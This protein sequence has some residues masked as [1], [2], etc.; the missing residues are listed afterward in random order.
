MNKSKNAPLTRRQA[1]VIQ[2]LISEKT[3][4]AAA[5]RAG[6]ARSTLYRWLRA[7]PNFKAELQRQVRDHTEQAAIE[8]KS[9]LGAAVGVLRSLLSSDNDSLK[10][11]A[12]VEILAHCTKFIE[13]EE[14]QDRLDAL[15]AK[16]ATP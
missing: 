16:A 15:E 3:L 13:L 7:D 2:L 1:V 12:A 5:E 11:R 14:V 8:L 9:S 4:C 10:L 6:I